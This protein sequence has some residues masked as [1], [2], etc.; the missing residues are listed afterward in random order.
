MRHYVTAV[1]QQDVSVPLSLI[2]MNGRTKP[3]CFFFVLLLYTVSSDLYPMQLNVQC[4]VIKK[5]LT[6]VLIIDLLV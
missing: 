3:N 6:F 4:F 5:D 2:H 1:T